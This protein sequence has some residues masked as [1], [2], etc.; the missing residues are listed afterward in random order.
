[1]KSYEYAPGRIL[2]APDGEEYLVQDIITGGSGNDWL[3]VTQDRDLMPST[4]V[5]SGHVKDTWFAVEPP[6]P[7]DS[8][9]VAQAQADAERLRNEKAKAKT[10]KKARKAAEAKAGKSTAKAAKTPKT[11]AK[12]KAKAKKNNDAPVP[13]P[14]PAAV[15]I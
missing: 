4:L 9:P 15:S 10:E 5:L 8:S 12:A 1:M 6:E 14:G 7:T 2:L 11:K 3:V 13:A